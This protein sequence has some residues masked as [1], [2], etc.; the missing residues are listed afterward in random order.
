[1]MKFSY[2][3]LFCFLAACFFH[4][5]DLHAVLE[6]EQ[7]RIELNAD[8]DDDVIDV[9]FAFSNTGWRTV[10]IE[11]IRTSC[12][13]T[14]ATPEK[15]VYEPGESGSID[16]RFTVGNRQGTQR[17]RISIVTDEASYAVEMVV[18]VPVAWELRSRVLVWREHEQSA[19]KTAELIVHDPTVESVEMRSHAESQWIASL[20]RDPEDT[21]RWTILAK[22][23]AFESQRREAVA[24]QMQRADGTTLSANLF[25]RM[26]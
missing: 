9:S 26:L 6:F 8:W 1:M 17:N 20:T 15:R 23:E 22:P 25:L 7:D 4:T 13:C 12:G 14:A 24:L 18:H 5:G 3:S 11:Q 10:E 16:A 21:S 19:E 2:L